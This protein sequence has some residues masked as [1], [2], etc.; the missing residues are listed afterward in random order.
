VWLGRV[1]DGD[2]GVDFVERFVAVECVQGDVHAVIG[3]G[4][5]DEALCLPARER[6]IQLP[7]NVP[8]RSAARP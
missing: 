3:C 1:C 7:T 6:P 4:A 8:A 5:A 2:F